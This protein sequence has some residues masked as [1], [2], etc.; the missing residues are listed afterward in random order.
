MLTNMEIIYIDSTYI[1]TEIENLTISLHIDVI[2][3][4]A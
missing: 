2:K 3:N 4:M 1:S